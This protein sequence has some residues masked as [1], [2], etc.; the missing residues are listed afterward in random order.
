MHIRSDLVL[1]SGNPRIWKVGCLMVKTSRRFQEE[2]KLHFYTH[3]LMLQRY[4][5]FSPYTCPLLTK[6]SVLVRYG[7]FDWGKPDKPV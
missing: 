2:V 7:G 5:S 4:T 3:F 6:A 1:S